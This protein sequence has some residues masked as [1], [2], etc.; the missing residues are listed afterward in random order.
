MAL[1]KRETFNSKPGQG[2]STSFVAVKPSSSTC[3]GLKKNGGMTIPDRNSWHN[4]PWHIHV[5]WN[6]KGLIHI[7]D[8]EGKAQL[9]FLC[10]SCLTRHLL[11]DQ[12]IN[13]YSLLR[14]QCWN[15]VHMSTKGPAPMKVHFLETS[16]TVSSMKNV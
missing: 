2:N 14:N 9:V 10:C 11:N 7:I 8:G 16:C 15:W 5:P 3:L 12:L 13:L 6:V 4:S 1:S